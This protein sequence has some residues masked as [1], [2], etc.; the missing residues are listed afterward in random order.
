MTVH[1]GPRRAGRL[2]RRGRRPAAARR[3][4]PTSRRRRPASRLAATAHRPG[5]SSGRGSLAALEA[6]AD[7][8]EALARA[9]ARRGR[10]GDRRDLRGPGAVRPRSRASSARR[11]RR[12]MPGRRGRGDPRQHGRAGRACS[13]RSTTSIS[14]RARR[15]SATSAGAWPASCAAT[16]R[17]T[18]GTP[19]AGRPIIVADDLDPSA[20]ATLRPELVAGIA[21]AGGAPTGH[22][23]IVARGARDPAGPRP[24][25][26]AS[27]GAVDGR[28]RRVDGRGAA[29]R[30]IVDPAI[31][32]I[33]A[34]RSR[35]VA[36]R[37]SRPTPAAAA[38]GRPGRGRRATSASVLEAEAAVRAGA[39]GIGLVRTELLFLGRPAPPSVAEQ[40]ATYARIRDAMG[41]AAGGLPDARRRR[42]QAG[43]PGRRTEPR[44]TRR[45]VSAASGSGSRRPDLLDDQL[46]ALVEAAAG[47]ELRVMLPMVVDGRGGRR[48]SA[49]GST[50]SMRGRGRRDGAARRSSSA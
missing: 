22:A 37:R 19:T 34:T 1:V 14:G 25:A 44:R 49:A 5:A 24:R 50:R 17:P 9:D 7:E 4:M 40:R 35:G 16:P 12:S 20:V 33:S 2:A 8:L 6:A 45:S 26:G 18:C 48:R 31:R 39:D 27:S 46:R 10:R 32:P 11:W 30:L 36:G 41:G 23:A 28:R 3:A 47:G 29:G 13:P 43:R 15:M 21:L 42:R 38:R